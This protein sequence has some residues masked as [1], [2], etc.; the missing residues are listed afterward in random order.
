MT[1]QQPPRALSDLTVVDVSERVAGAFCTRLLADFGATVIKVEPPAGDPLRR[2]GPFPDDRPDPNASGLFLHLNTNKQSVTLDLD[3]HAGR[4]L[5]KR[6]LANADLL[7]ESYQPGHMATRGLGY[8]DLAGDF[9]ELI[10]E[11]LTPYGHTGPYRDYKGDSL[12]AQA[13]CS[14]AYTSGD[15]DREPLATALDLAEYMAGAHGAVAAMAAVAYRAQHGGGQH[16]DLSIAE[17]LSMADDYNYSCYQAT[18]GVRRRY[19][20]RLL[21]NYPNDILPCKD[22]YVAFIPGALGFPANV[23]TLLGRPELAEHPLFVSAEERVF[24]WKE[25]EQLLEPWLQSHTCEEIL[26]QAQALGML[27]APVPTPADLLANRHLAQRGFFAAVDHHNGVQAALPGAPFEMSGTPS[28]R[29]RAPLLGEHT[30]EL[31]R[32]ELGLS[33]DEL[34][35]LR[36]LGIV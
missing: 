27:F 17:S 21:M 16:L 2:R 5:F 7:V 23:A 33:A 19:Y 15:P 4:V 13:L 32:D 11:S 24:R 10:Y 29:G 34:P 26:D 28:R 31:L 20:S 9:P 14:Y 36:A 35:R 30:A 12:A 3:S 6:L 8:D 1:Q 18:G 22:G 25:F